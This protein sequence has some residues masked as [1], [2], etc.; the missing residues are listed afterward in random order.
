[1]IFVIVKLMMLSAMYLAS[2]NTRTVIES[3]DKTLV[4]LNF[5]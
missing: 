4:E 3:S 1:M 5:A 2:I